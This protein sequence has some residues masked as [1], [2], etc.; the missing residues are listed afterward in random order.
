MS[1][2]AKRHDV[3]RI[4]LSAEQKCLRNTRNIKED[5]WIQCDCCKDWLHASCGGFTI[6]QYN[7]INKDNIWIKCIICCL[8]Q[9]KTVECDREDSSL[10]NLVQQAVDNRV[11]KCSISRSG[12]KRRK[13]KSKQSSPSSQATHL[14]QSVTSD[15][16]HLLST[17][18]GALLS[19]IATSD[20]EQSLPTEKTAQSSHA[21]T[22]DIKI[23]AAHTDTNV[24]IAEQVDS[25]VFDVYCSSDTDKILIIDSINNP[26]EYSSSKRIL[27]EVHNY[28]PQVKVDFAYSLAKGGVAIH[29]T[30][31]SDRDLLLYN[32]PE[33]SFG[34][35]VRHPPKGKGGLSVYVK[36]VDTSVDVYDF[37]RIIQKKGVSTSD[38]RRLTKRY[39][40]KPTQVI[41]VTCTHQ[42][43]VE[44]L[45]ISKIL[46]NNKQ[47][48]VEREKCVQV[49]RC[50]NCQSLGHTAKT[51]R[52]KKR[53]EFCGD[54][55]CDQGKC[56][57]SLKCVNCSGD[58]ASSSSK[59]PVYIVRNEVIAK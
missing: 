59:C 50:Y 19:H 35:G 42:V 38:I 10:S 46:I 12:K 16:G 11:S 1:Q 39:T 18:T 45:L 7:K 8:Y 4:C 30:C 15:S 23:H 58:H 20:T 41:K 57:R 32:S 36:G 27:Q 48:I 51:C 21:V 24:C 3:C 49:V 5:S 33:E 31:K 14:S 25:E 56:I 6:Q 52:N 13:R 47:C 28:F 54:S 26:L 40:G 17:D 34:G 53:C 43:D 37:D 44:K 29:T 55:Q 9:L 2:G 22:S